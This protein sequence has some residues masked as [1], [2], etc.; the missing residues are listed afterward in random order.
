VSWFLPSWF[1]IPTIPSS[2]DNK[3]QDSRH[4][5]LVP[6]VLVHDSRN[7]R[8]KTTRA[9]IQ[10]SVLVPAVLVHDSHNTE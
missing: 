7:S 9:K 10:N 5:V 1:M 3:S 8:V 4:S 2:Q 6:A